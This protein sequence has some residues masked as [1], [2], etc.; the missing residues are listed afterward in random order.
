MKD[1]KE[2]VWVRVVRILL[3][4]VLPLVFSA[5]AI[6]ATCHFNKE[7]NAKWEALNQP[8]I[9]PTNIT[10]VAFEELDTSIA[11]KRD[12]GYP[13]LYYPVIKDGVYTGRSRVYSELVF[14]DA[15]KGERKW[16]N[17]I[18]TKLDDVKEESKRLHVPQNAPLKKHIVFLFS[19]RNN[20]Q[21]AAYDIKMHVQ[22]TDD[23]G[24][25]EFQLDPISELAGGETKD[26]ALHDYVD[27]GVILGKTEHF[28]MTTEYKYAGNTKTTTRK[29]AYDM[30]GNAWTY[31]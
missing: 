1:R 30:L 4:N 27:T 3:L 8:R 2:R 22:V 18:M 15:D 5:F 19:F 13:I 10:L 20:G 11:V 14:W 23:A 12:W 9:T 7:Q 31:E 28:I 6:V 16:G 24:K 29:L 26:I 25:K 21:L 17:R